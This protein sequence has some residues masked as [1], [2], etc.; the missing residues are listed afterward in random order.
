[1]LAVA[2]PSLPVIAR[3]VWS[4]RILKLRYRRAGE[5]EARPRRLGPLGLVLKAGKIL[6]RGLAVRR[7]LRRVR[8]RGGAERNGEAGGDD[9][10]LSV[11]AVILRGVVRAII[12]RYTCHPMSCMAEA[13]EPCSG[14]GSSRS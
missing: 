7:V 11:H 3:A 4:E 9:L 13:T 8:G 5:S 2:L 10:R 14:A 1:M 12:A 6:R